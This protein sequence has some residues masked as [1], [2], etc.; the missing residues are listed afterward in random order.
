MLNLESAES[1][2]RLR[3]IAIEPVSPSRRPRQ[4]HDPP[5]PGESR[6]PGPAAHRRIPGLRNLHRGPPVLGGSGR[7]ATAVRHLPGEPP[8][9]GDQGD[10]RHRR[11]RTADPDRGE[12]PPPA[13]LR[14]DRPVACAALL[15]S[16]V[17]GPAARL[18]ERGRQAQHRGRR[19]RLSRSRPAGNP[20]PQ[21]RP[22][23]HPACRGQAHPWHRRHSRR[24]QQGAGPRRSRR[25]A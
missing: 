12:A 13:A 3:R 20:N 10:G 4:G 2:H 16:C 22:G 8:A 1:P 11:L 19:R 17:A 9:R 6:P 18:R 15:S 24:R 23:G 21:V 14:P 5:R 25:A 7:R